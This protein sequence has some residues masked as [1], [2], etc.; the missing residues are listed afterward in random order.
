MVF[1][2]QFSLRCEV[3]E[4][5]NGPDGWVYLVIEHSF[6]PRKGERAASP[7]HPMA[8]D[9]EMLDGTGCNFSYLQKLSKYIVPDL[10]PP[11]LFIS[12][13]QMSTQSFIS[14]RRIYN[15]QIQPMK[16]QVMNIHKSTS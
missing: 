16:M 10:K 1:Y 6:H 5:S 7:L 8:F 4:K 3:I 2:L 9:L 15:H 13:W 11:K 14:A 12:S